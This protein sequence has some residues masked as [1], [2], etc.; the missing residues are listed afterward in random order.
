[1]GLSDGEHLAFALAENR[2]IVTQDSDFIVLASQGSDHAGIVYY[3]PQS[4]TT[5][6]VIRS[7]LWLYEQFS[8]EDLH[9]RVEFL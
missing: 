8:A 9:N 5:K 3:K 2:V 4:R 1:M 6:Q 7:L